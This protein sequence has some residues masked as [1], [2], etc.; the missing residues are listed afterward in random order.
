MLGTIYWCL[1]SHR[2][3]RWMPNQTTSPCHHG[4][5]HHT[6]AGRRLA[7]DPCPCFCSSLKEKKVSSPIQTHRRIDLPHWHPPPPLYLQSRWKTPCRFPS[8]T[9]QRSLLLFSFVGSWD[10]STLLHSDIVQ[11]SALIRISPFC[12]IVWNLCCRSPS[13]P[14]LLL[15]L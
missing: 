5:A 3:V 13:F 9:I 6:C 12:S 7:A 14:N 10:N 2:P 15:H 1:S 4:H 8:S 11:L